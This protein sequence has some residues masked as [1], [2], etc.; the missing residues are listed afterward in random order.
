MADRGRPILHRAAIYASAPEAVQ[1]PDDRT[2]SAEVTVFRRNLLHHRIARAVIPVTRLNNI[3]WVYQ[4]VKHIFR[5]NHK[6]C[7]IFSLNVRK[8]Y[9]CIDMAFCIFSQKHCSFLEKHF[10]F[11]RTLVPLWRPLHKERGGHNALPYYIIY[12]FFSSQRLI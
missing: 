5:K 2:Y 10:Q 6:D 9:F 1:P 11:L 7:Y 4:K 8:Q 12:Y 3:T